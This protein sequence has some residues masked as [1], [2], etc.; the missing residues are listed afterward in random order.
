MSTSHLP[1]TPSRS[2]RYSL[3]PGIP[4][5]PLSERSDSDTNKIAPLRYDKR[6]LPPVE[7]K[8]TFP[9]S[10]SLVSQ[11]PMSPSKYLQYIFEDDT[12]GPSENLIVPTGGVLR[13]QRSSG[14]SSLRGPRPQP[15]SEKFSD[16]HVPPLFTSPNLSEST[17][18]NNSA[19]RIPR[20]R[21]LRPSG[22]HLRE[23][24]L[25]QH[26]PLPLPP[27]QLIPRPSATSLASSASSET[28][29]L[30]QLRSG[31]HDMTGRPRSHTATSTASRLVIGNWPQ[32]DTASSVGVQD[33][34]RRSSSSPEAPSGALLQVLKANGTNVQYPEM[35]QVS[36]SNLRA[37][38][39]GAKPLYSQPLKI[40]KKRA[41][42]HL[43]RE[44]S[45]VNESQYGGTS[46]LDSVSSSAMPRS[47]RADQS[48][49][50]NETSYMN[51]SDRSE[52]SG[53]NWRL[54]RDD[55]VGELRAPPL[56]HQRSARQLEP[57]PESRPASAK[58]SGS[59]VGSLYNFLNDSV[60]TWAR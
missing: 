5:S 52:S 19:P 53:E 41:Y 24:E 12:A 10:P 51:R 3:T 7:N 18:S 16:L 48:F 42:S 54:E 25:F 30:D 11:S 44:A 27:R 55:N 8:T 37:N 57:L 35:R 31:S 33:E 1:T 2:P 28:L 49:I 59:H 39:T 32:F 50:S 17:S 6:G 47:I 13:S 15:S 29:P 20:I 38:V 9:R 23:V 43:S 60:N 14:N 34:R 58:S 36:N 40:R 26:D 21:E 45:M 56:R 22:E 46:R 4:R